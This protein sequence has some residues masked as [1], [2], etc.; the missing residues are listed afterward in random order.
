MNISSD[1][2]RLITFNVLFDDRTDEPYTWQTR[3]NLVFN[4][5]HFHGADVFCLQEPLKNQVDDFIKSFPNYGHYSLGCADGIDEGQHMS[6][7]YLKEKFDMQ[8]SGCFGLSEKPELLGKVGWDAKNPRLAL[9]M[10]L[11]QKDTMKTFY[12]VCTHLDH[13]GENAR[14]QGALLIGKKL[15]E[16]VG[17]LPVFVCGDFNANS[18]SK[19]YKNMINYGFNDCANAPDII[20]YDLPYT[21]HKFLLGLDNSQLEIYR[22]DPRVLRVIDHIFYKGPVK[23]LR[24]GI[25]GDNYDGIYPSDHMPKICDILLI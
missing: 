2:I 15:E 7:F 3:K 18:E 8:E 25:L 11:L 1:C 14:Q 5:L 22:D 24:H 10:K 4:L 16:L 23:I 20:S 19:S 6:I 12:I 17:N 9:W 13:I 21:Y